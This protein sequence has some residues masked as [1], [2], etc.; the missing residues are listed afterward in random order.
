MKKIFDLL[1]P[2]NQELHQLS[3]LALASCLEESFALSLLIPIAESAL[4]FAQSGQIAS[5]TKFLTSDDPKCRTN[6]ALVITK[7]G[8]LPR[9]LGYVRESGAVAALVGNMSAVEVAVI[10]SAAMGL[11]NLAKLEINQIEIARLGGIEILM[12]LLSNDNVEVC[13]Q[14]VMT[15]SSMCLNRIFF[16]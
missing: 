9:N 7:L 13:R 16:R 11:V 10:S 15:L 8:K 2:E 12:R 3:L 6:S 14:A 4:T 5:I 1:V